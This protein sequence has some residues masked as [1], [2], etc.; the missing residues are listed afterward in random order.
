M[1]RNTAMHAARTRTSAALI[2]A[3]AMGLISACTLEPKYRQPSLPVPEQWP[4]PATT[5]GAPAASSPGNAM[6]V[7]PS[8]PAPAPA[9]A[10]AQTVAVR[11]IGWR[12][13]FNDK[14]LQ[15]IIA[16]ALSN[17]RDLRVAILNIQAAQAQYH[18][19]RANELPFLD[20]SGS[21]T[22]EELPPALTFG[23]ESFTSNIFQ[24]GIGVTNYQIDLFG[25]VRSLT[26]AALQQYLAQEEARRGTQLSLIAAIA[27]A[28][29]N[30]ASDKDLQHLAQQTLDSQE[31]SY[32]LAR[33]SHDAGTTSGL[34]LAQSQTTV[35]QAR[36]DCARYEGNVAQDVDALTLLVGAPIDPAWLPDSFDVSTMGLQALPGGLPSDVLLR[37]P[38]VLEAE[39]LLRSAN[40]NIGAARAA[41]FPSISL[42]ANIGSASLDLSHLFKSG[43]EVWQFEPQITLPIFHAGGVMG[44]LKLANSNQQIAVAQY[45][46]AIQSSFREVADALALTATLNRQR[47]AQEALVSATGRAY[48]LSQRR[49][50]AGRDS[51]INVLVSQRSDYSAQQGLIATR[52]AEQ[53]NRVNLYE[54]LGGGWRELTPKSSNP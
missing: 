38:D 15:N 21:M 2:G 39:H 3:L 30:L 53:T 45:E 11:D 44:A 23:T 36:A 27:N 31:H 4:I 33:R 46:K 52:L 28:Y 50:K 29:L 10:E 47:A 5:A 37:R 13:F 48:E 22:R 54:A 35:E 32:E 9:A 20:A 26:H 7:P 34:D 25:R 51:Y 16:A 8:A 18:I 41:F 43:T 14:R 40:G 42:T 49:Y 1:G 6:L 24:V 17:N 19:Q 12:D